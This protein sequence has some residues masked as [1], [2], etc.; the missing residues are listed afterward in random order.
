[1]PSWA[2]GHHF[3][4]STNCDKLSEYSLCGAVEIVIL[5][6]LE[7]NPFRLV[8]L[9]KLISENELCFEVLS[10]VTDRGMHKKLCHDFSVAS[11]GKPPIA[12]KVSV[13][14]YHIDFTICAS[15]AR[16]HN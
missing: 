7:D 14:V 1:M 13:R 4:P 16:P 10:F 2:H 5:I 3:R 11:R 9:A 12:S 15:F 8:L 6:V